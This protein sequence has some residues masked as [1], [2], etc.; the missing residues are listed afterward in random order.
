MK[1]NKGF[2]LIEIIAVVV[3]LGL[4]LAIAV[5]AVSSYITSSRKTSYI[6]TVSAY[7]E[8]IMSALESK[9]LGRYPGDKEIFIVPCE[10]IE[11]ESGDKD[12]SPFGSFDFDKSYVLVTAGKSGFDY[13]A[14]FVDEAK[15]GIIE[16]SFKDFSRDKIEKIDATFIRPWRVYRDGGENLIFNSKEYELCS[17][18]NYNGVENAIVVMCEK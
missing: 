7:V 14:N 15:Y 16:L 4:V 18:R 8:N 11:I 10:Y 2:T 6:S 17:T 5:P 13:Y 3:I 1:N 9:E 12:N